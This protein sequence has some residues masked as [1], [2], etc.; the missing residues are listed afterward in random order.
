MGLP[1]SLSFL[2]TGTGDQ[3][4]DVY[5]EP[6]CP[7][8]YKMAKSLEANVLPHVREG[9]KYHGKLQLV[10]RIYAQPFHYFSAFPC[11]AILVFCNQH[12]DLFWEYL[13]AAFAI[14]DAWFN[15]EV[16]DKTPLQCQQAYV[17]VALDILDKHGRLPAGPRS[18]AAGEWIDKLQVHDKANGGSSMF[19]DLKYL[20]REGRQNG[21]HFTPTVLLNGL[22]DGTVSSSFG[23]DDWDKYLA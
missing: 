7:F 6:L 9:G 4:L 2:R 13:M 14:Q 23:K 20:A 10:V 8:S 11:E 12:P 22:E 3:T 5:L 18:K 16:K 1:T 15:K 21:I 17:D 19:M